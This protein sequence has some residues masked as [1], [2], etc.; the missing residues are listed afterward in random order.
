MSDFRSPSP[1]K[2]IEWIKA[3]GG[4]RRAGLFALFGA[5]GG[6]GHPPLA[7]PVLTLFSLLLVFW[8]RPWAL[9]ARAAGWAGWLYGLGYFAVT[10][11][12]IVEPFLVDVARHGWMAPFAIFLLSGG[13]ALLWAGAFGLAGW[14]RSGA[15]LVLTWAGAEYVRAHLFG[16]FPWGMHVTALVDTLPYQAAAWLGPLGLTLALLLASWAATRRVHP[17]SLVA[18]ALLAVGSFLP[19]PAAPPA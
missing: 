8:A 1:A 16:G 4:L 5:L 13:L 11:H 2:P 19:P 12:W 9:G 6:L 15:T 17:L 18:V 3:L 7:W 10:L 14:R